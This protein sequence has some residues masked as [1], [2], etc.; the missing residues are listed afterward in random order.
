MIDEKY[1]N[2]KR[3][4]L[5]AASKEMKTY[6]YN[7]E[8]YVRVPEDVKKTVKSMCVYLTE[9]LGGMAEIG[10][11]EDGSVYITHR[12]NEDEVDFDNIQ[13]EYEIENLKKQ[14]EK[15]LTALT[16]W[17]KAVILKEIEIKED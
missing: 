6:Y 11:Y 9:K 15:L 7:D 12:R 14:E 1:E 5:C 13:I 10:F 8:D 2:M 17:Y 4:V 16:I 3:N